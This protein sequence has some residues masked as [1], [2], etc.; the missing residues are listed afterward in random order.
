MR[1]A[2]QIASER[3]D[4][5]SDPEVQRALTEWFGE[6]REFVRPASSGRR[7][8]LVN[9][10]VRAAVYRDQYGRFY[11]YADPSE[12]EDDPDA[13]TVPT[14]PVTDRLFVA[15][16]N[17][18][19]HNGEDVVTHDG[20]RLPEV[21][22]ELLLT[23]LDRPTAS[24]MTVSVAAFIEPINSLAARVSS[25]LV[26]ING[27]VPVRHLDGTDAQAILESLLSTRFKQ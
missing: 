26:E 25:G 21:D 27:F 1:A 4:E 16:G 19:R 22:E 13:E 23:R 2:Y 6:C 8:P 24:K 20:L 17:S 18:E 14:I 7:T 12:W 15:I 11:A 3:L 10:V 5:G 9:N